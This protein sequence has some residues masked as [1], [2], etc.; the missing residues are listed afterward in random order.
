M[1]SPVVSPLPLARGVVCWSLD[2][3]FWCAIESADAE[4]LERARGVL[5]P[6][7]K[8]DDEPNSTAL[9]WRIE[10]PAANDVWRAQPQTGMTLAFQAASLPG[11]LTHIEYGA[12]LCL[13][14]SGT[15]RFF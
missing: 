9:R 1:L 6:F 7:A 5:A 11:L 4:V 13:L 14:N 8:T 10:R 15:D 12:L 2:A 3:G